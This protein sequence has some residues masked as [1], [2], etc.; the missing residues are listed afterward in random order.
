MLEEEGHRLVHLGVRD[1]VVVLDHEH[2]VVL[3]SIEIVDH[4]RQDVVHQTDARGPQDPLGLRPEVRCQRLERLY[5][6]EEEADRVVVSAIQS[7]PREG[8]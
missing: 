5:H 8:S 4:D 1:E 6:V 7:E 2:E 3:Q